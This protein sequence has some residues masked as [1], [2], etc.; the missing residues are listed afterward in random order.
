MEYQA[1][2]QPKKHARIVYKNP[3]E[4]ER[5]A[6]NNLTGKTPFPYCATGKHAPTFFSA[7]TR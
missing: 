7:V 4:K 6:K 3:S 2:V 5:A 1:G